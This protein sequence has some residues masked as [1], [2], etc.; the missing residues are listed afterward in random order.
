VGYEATSVV[1]QAVAVA[2][3]PDE[4]TEVRETVATTGAA[5]GAW[6]PEQMRSPAPVHTKTSV[7][8]LEIMQ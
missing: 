5:V 2:K 4:H 8:R 1:S 6:V 3:L 7:S